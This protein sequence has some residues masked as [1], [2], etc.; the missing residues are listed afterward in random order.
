MI[1]YAQAKKI[2]IEY[3][4]AD[5][6]IVETATLERPYGWYF[7]GQSKAYLQ[8]GDER[9]MLF[10]SGGFVVEREEG[11]VFEFGSLYPP[12]TWLANYEKGFKYSYYD[13]IIVAIADVK[14]TVRLLHQLSMNFVVPEIAHGVEWKIPQSY[15]KIRLYLQ[16]RR[17][18]CVFR[19]Q[20]FWHRVNVF[21]ELNASECCDFELR[22]HKPE[23]K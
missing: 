18:P 13:L 22:E 20:V 10:G 17:L 8:T 4:G 12:E 15:G 6:G 11:R 9:E 16:L 23:R 1:D 19:N 3:V 5:C 2:A 7:C 21:D 14:T